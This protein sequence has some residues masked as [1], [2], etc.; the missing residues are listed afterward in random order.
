MNKLFSICLICFLI[1]FGTINV[2]W[3]KNAIYFE[4]A[5]TAL[6][7][8]IN[9]EFLFQ[10][11]I[12]IRIGLGYINAKQSINFGHK[13]SE[14]QELS[15]IPLTI[16]KLAGA[17][18]HNLE[19]GAGIVVKYFHLKSQSDKEKNGLLLSAL[20]GCRYQSLKN[21]GLLLR[22]TLRYLPTDEKLKLYTGISVGYLF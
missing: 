9:Y 6:N 8:S 4:Y 10:N 19:L 18:Q 16:G 12:P 21:K 20:I 17:N 13:F 7:S 22:L 11:D 2:G 1:L 14:N 5:G 15:L 3:T